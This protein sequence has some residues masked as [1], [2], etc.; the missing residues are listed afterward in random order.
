MSGRILVAALPVRGIFEATDAASLLARIIRSLDRSLAS[1]DVVQFPIVDGGTG[2]IDFLV[3]H[4]LGSFLEV[5][6][7]GASGEDVVVPIGFA[8]E[9]GKLAVIEMSRVARVPHLG[10]SGTTV[11]IGQLI[12]DA[13]DE[14]AFSI[15]LGHEEPLACD[16]GLGAASAL[17]V[18]FLDASNKEIDFALP[19][20]SIAHIAKVD[21]STRS[22]SLLS[23]RIFIARAANAWPS[24][25]ANGNRE[26]HDILVKLSEIIRRD[27]GIHPST[28]NL[29]ASAVEFGLT[30]FLAAEVREGTS[31]VLE[32]SRISDAIARGEFSEFILLV[33]Q[34]EELEDDYLRTLIDLARNNVKHCAILVSEGASR[35]DLTSKSRASSGDPEFYLQDV[36]LFQASLS[37]ESGIEERRRDLTMRLEK[38]MPAVLQALRGASPA[39]AV[40]AK[41]SR[42]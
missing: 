10:D 30:A 23:S 18:K 40:T 26:L 12:Q 37:D 42:A 6:A 21:A 11:G 5:E 24:K 22:F 29:S 39:K 1:T 35:T 14:G 15:L 20:G 32:A 16:A 34:M 38:I 36:E 25:E 13:L 9:D 33:P 7:T 19:G 31:L 4:T 8:G 3:T 28:A 27:T 41:G 2:T 17:G